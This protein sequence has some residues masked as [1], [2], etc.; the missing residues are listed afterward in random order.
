MKTALKELKEKYPERTV[1]YVSTKSISLGAGLISYK[2]AQLHNAGATD[3]EV[4]EFV[5]QFRDK[6]KTYFVVD[7]LQHLKRGGRVSSTQAVI[8]GML[9]IKP[10]L[11]VTKEGKL[12]TL[13]KAAGMKKA[14]AD[15][16][17]KVQE[18][19]DFE[20]DCPIGILHA[21]SLQEA[22][23]LK[24]KVQEVVG[25][26]HEIWVQNVGPT[27]GTHCGPGT[28]GIA[29]VAKTAW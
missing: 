2:A 4:I 5:E 14:V 16:V 25:K 6:M 21:D 12:E 26:D 29:F 27:V 11:Y 3:D 23:L 1:K 8:G 10:I 18:E 19:C 13:G 7:S 28:L 17:N 24:E 22:E 15:F 9:N 20:Y